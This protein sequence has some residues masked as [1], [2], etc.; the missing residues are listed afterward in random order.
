MQTITLA[1]SIPHRGGP[2]QTLE[3]S[4]PTVDSQALQLQEFAEGI[5]KLIQE[6]PVVQEAI[7]AIKAGNEGRKEAEGEVSTISCRCLFCAKFHI[8]MSGV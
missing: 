1:E 6:T 4:L 2:G 3:E 7:L 8:S 5:A